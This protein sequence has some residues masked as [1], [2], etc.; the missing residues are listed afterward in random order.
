[1]LL[2]C[3]FFKKAVRLYKIEIF[4]VII[5][6]DSLKTIFIQQY[7]ESKLW[8]K[9]NVLDN[10]RLELGITGKQNKTKKSL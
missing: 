5:C 7:G 6:I 9:E 4:V 2:F 1:M 10:S 8:I 3:C